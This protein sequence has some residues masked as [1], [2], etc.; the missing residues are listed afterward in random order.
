MRKSSGLPVAAS[1][2]APE[3]VT[4][5]ALMFLTVTVC[6]ALVVPSCRLPNATFDGLTASGPAT[7]PSTV[8]RFVSMQ[9]AI[10]PPTVGHWSSVV[11]LTPGPSMRNTFVLFGLPRIRCGVTASPT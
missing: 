1:S 11:G 8:K 10:A 7:L 4:F 3:T 9:S 2:A 5:E 6:V